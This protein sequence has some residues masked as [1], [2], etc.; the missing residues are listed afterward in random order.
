[1]SSIYTL[2]Y[3]SYCIR[4]CFHNKTRKN[5]A[6]LADI[7]TKKSDLICSLLEEILI[8]VFLKCIFTSVNLTNPT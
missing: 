5:K 7:F 3:V 4:Q 8:H 6:N 2:V 1:M